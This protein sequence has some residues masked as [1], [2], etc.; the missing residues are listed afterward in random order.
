MQTLYVAYNAMS[1]NGN[2]ANGW[3]TLRNCQEPRSTDDVV[4]LC[5]KIEE[6]EETITHVVP[7][8]WKVL[9]G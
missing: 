6:A 8:W 5:Q 3:I 1:K 2:L 9:A 7:V 4:Q